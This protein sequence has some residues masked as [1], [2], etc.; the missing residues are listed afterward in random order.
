[1]SAE[2]A[3]QLFWIEEIGHLPSDY[4]AVEALNVNGPT[5]GAYINSKLKLVGKDSRIE[6]YAVATQTGGEWN[7]IFGAETSDNADDTLKIRRNGTS[8]LNICANHDD[9][10]TFTVQSGKMFYF[11]LEGTEFT[12]DDAT[13]T[14]SW[15]SQIQS[16]ELFIGTQSLNG[17]LFNNSRFWLGA[18]GSLK[19]QSNG[20]IVGMFIP[21]EHTTSHVFGFYDLVTKQFMT[22]LTNTQ[23]TEWQTA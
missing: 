23:F 20:K 13:K 2:G 19:F 14:L 10:I 17:S 5:N 3:K 9:G 22:S 21:C 7:C 1:M 4:Q 11:C 6:G 18:I 8:G 16:P 12:I 15:T